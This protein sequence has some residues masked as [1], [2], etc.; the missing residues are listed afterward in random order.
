MDFVRGCFDG[1]GNIDVSF[2]PESK[3]PQLRLR[4]C[5]A[6]LPFVNWIKKELT[7]QLHIKTGWVYS[8]SKSMHILSYGK[9]DSIKILKNMYYNDVQYYLSRKY[10]V[11][12]RFIK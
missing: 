8:N 1:D 4:L 6:S 11:A 2:H 5:S 7:S 10:K 9:A 3:H 12:S